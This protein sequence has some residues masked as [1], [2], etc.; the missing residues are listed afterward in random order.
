MR[1]AC[2]ARLAQAAPA[3]KEWLC[4][5]VGAWPVAAII[6]LEVTTISRLARSALDRL[7]GMRRLRS[8]GQA[9]LSRLA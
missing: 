9:A 1:E 4:E 7:N 5:G 2:R 3:S 8:L 6:V